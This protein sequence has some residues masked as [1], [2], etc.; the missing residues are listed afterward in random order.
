MEA[1]ELRIGNWVVNKKLHEEI[2]IDGNFPFDN[3]FMIEPIPLTEEWLL[4]F[5]WFSID[6]DRYTFRDIEYY[7]ISNE[8][9]LYFCGSYTCTDI[10]Y[11]HQLQNLYFAL[12][13]EELTIKEVKK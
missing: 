7:T 13:G 12:T 10:K 5:D 11:V 4:K 6:D 3:V 2:Q 9:S 8:G 1:N